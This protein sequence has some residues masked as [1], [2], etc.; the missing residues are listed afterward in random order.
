MHS[1]PTHRVELP[2]RLVALGAPGPVRSARGYCRQR[3]AASSPT[4]PW[5]PTSGRHRLIAK[6]RCSGPAERLCWTIHRPVDPITERYRPLPG[7]GPPQRKPTIALTRAG[8][9]NDSAAPMH[10]PPEECHQP[11][12]LA[13]QQTCAAPLAQCLVAHRKPKAP[14]AD[15]PANAAPASQ[16]GRNSVTDRH[17]C[18]QC[19]CTPTFERARNWAVPSPPGLSTSGGQQQPVADFVADAREQ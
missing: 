19:R 3:A 14:L 4:R 5:V 10:Q 8:G 15:W 2:A 18:A 17:R 7:T 16:R 11:A 12:E 6:I 1:H 13:Q 9:R